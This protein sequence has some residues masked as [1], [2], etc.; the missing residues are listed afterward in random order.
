MTRVTTVERRSLSF[1]TFLVR[2]KGEPIDTIYYGRTGEPRGDAGESLLSE[3]E[4]WSEGETRTA[5]PVL[6]AVWTRLSARCVGTGLANSG[7]ERRRGGR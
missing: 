5:V 2:K 3:A 1:D 4:T 6:C 7:K